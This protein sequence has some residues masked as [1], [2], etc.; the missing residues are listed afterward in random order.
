MKNL[1]ESHPRL[2]RLNRKSS[3]WVKTELKCESCGISGPRE[4]FPNP[5]CPVCPD[6]EK[7]YWGG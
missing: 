3:I 2:K 1:R 7:R 4:F 6:C 5:R